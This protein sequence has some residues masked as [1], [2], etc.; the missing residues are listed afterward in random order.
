MGADNFAI[1]PCQVRRH[2][3]GSQGTVHSSQP[4]WFAAGSPGWVSA[5][6]KAR[7][8]EAA[9]PLMFQWEHIAGWRGRFRAKQGPPSHSVRKPVTMAPL[10][11]C[12]GWRAS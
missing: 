1:Q 5:F 11:R 8:G 3:C 10:S 9:A 7:A 2:A 12:A 4:Y 6:T